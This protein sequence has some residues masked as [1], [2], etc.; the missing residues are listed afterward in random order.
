MMLVP[1]TNTDQ[2]T[3]ADASTAHRLAVVLAPVASAASLVKRRASG[4][5][6]SATP[7]VRASSSACA[8]SDVSCTTGLGAS[9][10]SCLR[11]GKR[12]WSQN[13][14]AG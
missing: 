4:A 12:S 8:D 2:N 7:R 10:L 14:A 13:L 3:S 6:W 11:G 1:S 5:S 9:G